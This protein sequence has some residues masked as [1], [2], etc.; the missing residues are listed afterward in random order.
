MTCAPDVLSEAQTPINRATGGVF[1]INSDV[2][3]NSASLS[4]ALTFHG[5]KLLS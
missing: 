2:H 1:A 3:R 5:R 4:R